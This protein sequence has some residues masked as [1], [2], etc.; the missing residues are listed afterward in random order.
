MPFEHSD[1]MQ[2]FSFI[3]VEGRRQP[4]PSH[5]R[6]CIELYEEALGN[7]LPEYYTKF[8]KE[9]GFLAFSPRSGRVF[10]PDPAYPEDDGVEIEGF[11]GVTGDPSASLLQSYD[12]YYEYRSYRN[13]FEFFG[14]FVPFNESPDDALDKLKKERFSSQYLPIA[15]SPG[16]AIVMSLDGEDEGRIY[17]FSQDD[18]KVRFLSETFDKLLNGLYIKK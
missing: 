10:F 17:F 11:F 5:W 7:K 16:G 9:Y 2:K 18:N 13:P 12:I 6:K 8:L 1:M 15:S 14:T 3:A 4:P